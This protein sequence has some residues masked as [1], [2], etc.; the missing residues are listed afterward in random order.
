MLRENR[1]FRED[2]DGL[3]RDERIPWD[4]LR[5]KTVYLTGAT[6]LIGYAL[7]SALLHFNLARDGQI[8]VAA[9][10][11]DRQK[12]EAKFSDWLDAGAALDF[13]EGP[14]E[15]RCQIAGPVDYVVHCAA[16]TTSAY[17]TEHPVE[18]IDTIYAGT[19]NMLELARGKH[20]LGAV[21]LSSMEVYGQVTV[22]EK[23]GAADLGYIDLTSPRSGYPEGKRL[24][25][26]LC[27]AYAAQYGVPVTIA[28]LAQTFGPGVSR[29]D[30]RVFAYMARCAL[31]GE[32]IRLSTDGTKENMYLY[33]MDAVSAILLLL[34]RGERGGIYNVAN[35]ST[36][37]SV[38]EM[39]ELVAGTLA[40]SEI[41]V[42]V[43]AG[44][45]DVK[46]Y[47][48]A[49]YLNLDTSKLQGLGWSAKFNLSEMYLR[50]FGEQLDHIG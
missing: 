23:L 33:T 29:E 13:L 11:R 26:N 47:P 20:A 48:P 39:G 30:G 43:N 6:G 5:G 28:R 22:R 10:V 25:E 36:Y 3:L 41:G 31:A 1:V 16:P 19:K 9:L 44:Q 18:T 14:V 2:L 40:K 21:F 50:T 24:A 42:I 46:R 17:L 27:C 49:G 45:G 34:V 8:K 12:A 37:C 32:D 35:E 4:A 15:E 7:T 38:R